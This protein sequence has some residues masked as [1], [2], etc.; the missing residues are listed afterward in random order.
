MSRGKLPSRVGHVAT[1]SCAVFLLSLQGCAVV[2]SNDCAEKASCPDL[3]ATATTDAREAAPAEAST[4]DPADGD[5]DDGEPAPRDAAALSDDAPLGGGSDGAGDAADAARDASDGSREPADSAPDVAT[6]DSGAACDT[7][8]PDCSN[9]SCQPAFACIPGV[10]SG[11]LGPVVLFERTG[12]GAPAPAAP[13]CPATPPYASDAYDGHANPV[14]QGT[15]GCSCGAAAGV[16]TGPTVAIYQDSQCGTVCITVPNVSTCAKGCPMATAKSASITAAPSPSG[17]SCPASLVSAIAP[18]SAATDWAT[19]ARACGASAASRAVV[20]GGCAASQ[21][22]ADA[23]PSTASQ[24][25]CVYQSGSL[26]CPA[27]YPVDHVYFTGGTDT[28]ACAGTCACGGPTGVSCT[29]AGVSVS[30]T[31]DCAAPA[32]LADT[33]VG[34]CNSNL[35]ATA[36][37]VTARVTPSGG[38]CA[39]S[40]NPSVAG[41]IVP[42]APT[43]VCCTQ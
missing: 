17:G 7:S 29:I 2:S 3:D 43:T 16:C 21:L 37:N 27:G 28:R 4:P 10:P 36:R 8:H 9:P 5:A 40:G 13:A 31:S 34:Q 11:W 39:P 20:Q 35:A 1:T 32:T 19:T 41:G 12:A 14:S 23:P 15:C 6:P 22:C 30:A 38:R 25:W 42:A 24:A 33:T 26:A 18:W